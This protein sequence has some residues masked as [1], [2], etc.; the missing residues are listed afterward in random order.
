MPKKKKIGRTKLD[1]TS[2]KGRQSIGV[3]LDPKLARAFKKALKDLGIK[4]ASGDFF[5]P[6]ILE[7]LSKTPAR[8]RAFLRRVSSLSA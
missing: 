5:R 4:N 1:P 2:R 7:F 3:S 8:Q 6:M